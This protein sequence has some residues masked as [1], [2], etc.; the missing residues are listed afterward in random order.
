MV[1]RLSCLVPSS[2][3]S[4]SLFL[5]AEAHPRHYDFVT[6]VKEPRGRSVE[7]ASAGYR[8]VRVLS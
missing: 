8:E 1:E 7:H 5:L 6:F 2:Q 3:V 4:S